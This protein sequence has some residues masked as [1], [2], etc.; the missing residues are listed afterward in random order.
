MNTR[1]EQ[2]CTLLL[3]QTAYEGAHK[4]NN[5][6]YP[7]VAECHVDN[8]RRIEPPRQFDKSKKEYKDS[9]PFND[10]A[11]NEENCFKCLAKIR[12][13]IIHA[14]KAFDP[15]SHVRIQSLLD[16]ACDFIDHVNS[17]DCEFTHKAKSIKSALE[18]ENF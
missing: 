1:E 15:D 4:L 6:H 8:L 13:N 14:N 3:N 18:I 2:I 9:T 7:A 5:E 12:D 17:L 10:D 16:W 11:S